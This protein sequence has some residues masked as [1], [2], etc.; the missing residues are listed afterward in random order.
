[1][2]FVPPQVSFHYEKWKPT[3]DNGTSPYVNWCENSTVD[4]IDQENAT[5]G[6]NLADIDA[7]LAQSASLCQHIDG[8][9]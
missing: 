8:V 1:M 3:Y 7:W 5:I 9:P 4:C 6:S 2:P